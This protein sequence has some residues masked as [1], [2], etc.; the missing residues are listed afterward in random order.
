ML[1]SSMAMAGD[2]SIP[3]HHPLTQAQAG[4]VLMA[5]LRCAACHTDL[6]KHPLAEKIA[7]SLVD[8][9][10]RISPDYLRR[11]LASPST[12]H[13]G[14]S[15]PDMLVA[16]PEHER[17]KVADALT[18]F[19]VA[20]SQPSK[21]RNRRCQS[22]REQGKELFHS[23]GCVACHGPRETLIA[24]QLDS[25]P[26]DNEQD[27]IDDPVLARRKAIKPS[28]IPLEHVATKYTLQSLSEFLFQPLKYARQAACPT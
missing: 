24:A 27:E 25:D 28:A 1:A 26:S 17:Q 18:H 8:I 6:A 4:R 12:T 5:E 10:N 9:G 2:P 21:A 23:I 20:Q 22:I 14:T 7:P 3:G 11:F 19:L 13:P 16:V 15:M